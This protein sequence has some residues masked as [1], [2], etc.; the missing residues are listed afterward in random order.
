MN[1]VRRNIRVVIALWVAVAFGL[2]YSVSYGWGAFTHMV[3]REA[4]HLFSGPGVYLAALFGFWTLERKVPWWPTLRGWVAL[5]APAFAALFVILAW[6]MWDG[7]VGGSAGDPP[8]KSV[9][10]VFLGWAAGLSGGVYGLYRI[11]PYL[12]RAIRNILWKAEQ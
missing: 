6:E 8:I 9:I 7:R 12:H 3:G 2:S 1:F 4:I 11:H 5:I 10:D